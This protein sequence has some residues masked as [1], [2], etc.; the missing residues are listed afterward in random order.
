MRHLY[1]QKFDKDQSFF[2]L[3]FLRCPS[4]LCVEVEV[5]CLDDR[6]TFS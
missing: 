5:S 4:D 2:C 3:E 1:Y 6:S